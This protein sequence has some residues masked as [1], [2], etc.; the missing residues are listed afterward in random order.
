MAV[1][2]HFESLY[3]TVHDQVLHILEKLNCNGLFFVSFFGIERCQYMFN[4]SKFLTESRIEQIC[5]V[6]AFKGEI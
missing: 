6:A 3:S 1:H 5:T 4:L 2:V